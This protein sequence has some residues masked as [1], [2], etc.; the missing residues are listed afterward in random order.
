M[1]T[2]TTI[3]L[4]VLSVAAL[5]WIILLLTPGRRAATARRFARSIDLDLPPTLAPAIGRR[6]AVRELAAMGTGLL[7]GWGSVAMLA[8]AID[9]DD[10]GL[11]LAA[12]FL[13]FL[14]GH[15]IG[16]GVTAW[17]EVTRPVAPTGPRV[18][19]ATVLTQGDYVA[20]VERLGAR[21]LVAV[22]VVVALGV[23][24]ADDAGW[25][26]GVTLPAFW[27]AAALVTP[28]ALLAAHELLAAR[29]VRRPQP[30]G[31][32]LDL[33]WDDAMRSQT[34]RDMVTVPLAAGAYAPLAV[35][36]ALGEQL[37]GAWPRSV[38]FDIVHGALFV[39]LAALLV[40][41]VI[42]MALRPQRHFR[43]RLWPRPVG[44]G[45]GPSSSG[46]GVVGQG[47]NDL[48]PEQGTVGRARS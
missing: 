34:L 5:V 48:A 24:V 31:S 38:V 8:A 22:S 45:L 9:P 19:R 28:P 10:A 29:L 41:A 21:V 13:T 44:Q 36:G 17:W 3:V 42:A 25:F 4:V 7:L 12:A 39:L 11:L 47:Q 37:D 1:L 18:A 15:A 20:P 14:L 2:G 46:Q 32:A 30:A 26:T 23:L 35:L 33:A 6:L 40:A 16:N 27:I 43:E